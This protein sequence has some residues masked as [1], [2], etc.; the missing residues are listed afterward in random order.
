M[1]QLLPKFWAKFVAGLLFVVMTALCLAAVTGVAVLADGGAYADG[2][3]RLRENVLFSQ[4][5]QNVDIV[6][7]YYGV[8]QSAQEL[9]ENTGT[10]SYYESRFAKEN[11]NYFF[12]ITDADGNVLLS[13][14]TDAYQYSDATAYTLHR[15]PQPRRETK[16]FSSEE[17][18]SEYLESLYEQY[19]DR[20]VSASSGSIVNEQTG[21]ET[22]E[23]QVQ[24]TV[25]DS[26]TV[27]ITGYVRSNLEAKDEIY[28][29]LF[30]LDKLISARNW[31][32]VIGASSLVL[33]VA[34]LV[35]LLSSAG[36]KEGEEKIHL[37]WFDR[38]PLDLLLFIWICLG[39]ITVAMGDVVYSQTEEIVFA[40]MV[41]LC[42]VPL[43]LVLLMSFASRVKAG[44][45]FKNNVLYWLLTKIKKFLLWL[46][47]G[48]CY[49]VRS[50][51]LYWK[52]GVFWAALS[53]LEMMFVLV[54][55]SGETLT[56]WFFEKLVLTAVSYTH[57]TLPTIC[58][59]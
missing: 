1:K 53:L 10:L 45:V 52:A 28:Y 14:Y 39:G 3:T 23:L 49:L 6:A 44:T 15:N 37:T 26:E 46:W 42:W 33:T 34:L 20:D 18:M 7:D 43:I 17:A 32:I 9:G 31:L 24:Y 55:G 25:Y 51:P 22:F 12:T 19:G 29:N 35:F 58:S 2:G 56:F 59:V 36:H 8:Y 57:L 21:E 50:L 54:S 48:L 38:I 13:N 41:V 40:S 11:S 47:H 16:T 30:W 27:T 5:Y 4:V